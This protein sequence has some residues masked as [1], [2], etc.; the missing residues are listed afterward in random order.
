MN[1]MNLVVRINRPALPV[2]RV[3]PDRLTRPNSSEDMEPSRLPGAGVLF[4]TAN[5]S[6]LQ[7]RSTLGPVLRARESGAIRTPG[8]K[9]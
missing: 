3:V 2:L 6:S 9:S 7:R 5:G 1:D 8:G 4:A